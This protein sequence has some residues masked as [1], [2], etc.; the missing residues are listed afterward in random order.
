MSKTKDKNHVLSHSVLSGV[1]GV[2]VSLT[3]GVAYAQDATGQT[4]PQD[5]TVTADPNATSE[6][7]IVVTGTRVPRPDYAYSNPVTSVT[8]EALEYSGE[9]NVTDFLTSL[10][11][12][13]NSTDSNDSSGANTGIGGTGLNLLN[14][15]NLGTDR[16]L[17]LVNGRRHVSSVPG[18]A[19]VDVATIP[20]E[21]I[22]RIDV[23][24]GGASA[25]YGA[26]GVSGVVNFILKDD[27]EGF[28]LRAQDSWT[29]LGGAGDSFVSGIW[30]VNSAGGRANLTIAGEY[31]HEGR[32]TTQ[33]RRFT[34]NGQWTDFFQNPA[35][36][37]GPDDP[38]VPDNV[39]IRDARISFLG[40]GGAFDTDF[41][42]NPDFDG[43]GAPWDFGLSVDDA[44]SF[45]QGGSG[46]PLP[47]LFTD[48]LPEVDRYVANA[49]F[50]Y[51]FSP[52]LRFYTELKYVN[53]Q[54][55]SLGQATFDQLLAV[56]V[57]NPFV[58]ANV[59]QAAN[60][61]GS[62][63]ILFN[64]YN[65]DLGQRGEDITRETIRA[66]FGFSGDISD[67]LQFDVSAVYGETSTEAHNLNDRWNDRFAAAID[68]VDVD[69]GPGQD[70]RCRIDVGPIGN[71]SDWNYNDPF[72]LGIA[73][74]TPTSFTPGPNSGCVP[75][76]IFGDGAPSQ[77]AIDWVT[78]D[79]TDKSQITQSVVTGYVH[80]DLDQWIHL[81]GGS[82][83]F[84]AGVEYRQETSASQFDPRD[85]TGLTFFNVLPN[86]RGNFHVFEAFAELDLPLLRHQ[87]FADSLA[88]DAAVRFSNY[89]TVGTTTSWKVGLVYAPIADI[90][91]RSTLA[92]AVRAP[93]IG[94]LFDP[95]GQDFQFI[96]DPCDINVLNQGTTF[97]EANCATILSGLGVDP[98]TFHDPNATNIDGITH[99]NRDL[100]EETADTFTVG[101]I[102]RP[103]WIQGLTLSADWYDIELSNAI[104]TLD[105]QDIADQ[106]VDSPDINNMFC[107]AITRR[108]TDGGIDTFVREPVNVA[109]FT[110]SGIDFS[111]AY[112]FAPFDGAWGNF[113][114]RLVGNHLDELTFVNLPGSVPT[115][116]DG[117]PGAPEWQA[118][119][120]V[121]WQRG[122]LTVN[123]GFNY[124]SETRRFDR[125]V[126]AAEPDVAERRYLWIDP[127]A[128]HDVQVR[129]DFSDAF[130]LYGGVNNIGNQLPDIGQTY[131][132]V[133]AEG[134]TFYVGVNAHMH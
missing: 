115:P 80:G 10:P 106:C 117:D 122:P 51:D 83:G 50:H 7:E 13:T 86:S 127:R 47:E 110:T 130:T 85:Q 16:T 25:V 19:A 20:V 124:F 116:S 119:L 9:T 34:R 89:T 82:A 38:N 93:N 15:R 73:M 1:A 45:A 101:V 64:R 17:V 103:H 109:K 126:V 131:F 27:Y 31:S 94:E 105:P 112:Q 3:G 114:V 41:D 79:T 14:L 120:D 54:S 133:G 74:P 44:G 65:N 40:A 69:P 125:N 37:G 91:F 58:P 108:G 71:A 81:Q 95:G 134:R 30:G 24:T 111:V 61:A 98:T 8:S 36:V 32:L 43:A 75:L 96:N 123:Y 132:P 76:N 11:A 84:A 77:A 121:V 60:D 35:E 68:V 102:V 128:T 42:G 97:R 56:D 99:G 2:L 23:S 21:L 52:G 18:S 39:P 59:A 107:D 49:M 62:P 67:H 4:T 113:G 92:E 28:G 22:D 66:V 63:L 104:N 46:L 118:N 90:T 48:I 57:D 72:G 5:Q 26:D 100:Q 55:F 6:P 33:Q 53:T 70:L 88:V 78:L 29:E 12:L 87:P 129:W